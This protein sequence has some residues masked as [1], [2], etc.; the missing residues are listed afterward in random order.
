MF[1][2]GDRVDIVGTSKGKG[3]AGV[4]KKYHFA[5][6]VNT[7][8][9]H[10]YYR[11][12]GSIGTT[13]YPGRV[14]KNRKMPGQLGNV[15]RTLQNAEVVDVKAEESLIFLKGGI[16]GSKNSVVLIRP[17]NKKPEPKDRQQTL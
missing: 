16:P 12:G 4:M 9:T 3:F 2:K 10:K 14:L 5:G 8:G 17:A 11:H 15:R 6:K 13:T 1:A 7:H